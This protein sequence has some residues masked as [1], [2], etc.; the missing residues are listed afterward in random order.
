MV[1]LSDRIVTAP[2]ASLAPDLEAGD[3]V[4]YKAKGEEAPATVVGVDASM[5]WVVDS[6]SGQDPLL[7][8]SAASLVWRIWFVHVA[9]QAA[10]VHTTCVC[11]QVVCLFMQA[12]ELC[13][14]NGEWSSDDSITHTTHCA[15]ACQYH[16]D[17]QKAKLR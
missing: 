15:A 6:L 5:W 17:Q 4:L 14:V 12:A 10:L 11:Q 1:A 9:Q 7:F 8:I 3:T 13:C 16:A 2:E